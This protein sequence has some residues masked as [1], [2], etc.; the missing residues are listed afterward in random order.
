MEGGEDLRSECHGTMPREDGL[1]A[2]CYEETEYVPW[3]QYEMN[4]QDPIY[5]YGPSQKQIGRFIRKI[6]ELD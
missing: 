6:C 2:F 3:W 4:K 5:S 1:C